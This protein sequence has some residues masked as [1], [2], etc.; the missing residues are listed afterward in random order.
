MEDL[1]SMKR[2]LSASN[3]PDNDSPA[4]SVSC[5]ETILQSGNQSF[6]QWELKAIPD[7]KYDKVRL[8]GLWI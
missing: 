8:S 1:K 2:D 3:K 5:S 7:V 4:L 6:V